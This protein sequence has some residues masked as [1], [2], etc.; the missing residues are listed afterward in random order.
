[1]NTVPVGAPYF[2]APGQMDTYRTWVR[3]WAT[4]QH[5]GKRG[6]DRAMY[7][8]LKDID[9]EDWWLTETDCGCKR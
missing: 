1:M 3:T 8:G 6:M 9:G 4:C 5:C 2:S 7:Y